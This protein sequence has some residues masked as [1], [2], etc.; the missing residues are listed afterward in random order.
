M[1]V[2]AFANFFVVLLLVGGGFGMGW[3][4][5][6]LESQDPAGSTESLYSGVRA[7]YPGA[8][9]DGR[10]AE[11]PQRA[12]L[13]DQASAATNSAPAAAPQQQAE[14]RAVDAFRELLDARAYSAAMDLYTR[15]ERTGTTGETAELK[16][17]VVSYLERYLRDRDDTALTGLVDAFLARYYDDVDVILILARHHLQSDYP[18]EAAGSFQLA[19]TYAFMPAEQQKVSR[20]FSSFVQEVDDL[21]A[22]QAHWKK[23]ITFYETLAVMDLSQPIH[24]LRQAELYLANGEAENGR[25][26]LNRLTG[27]ATV[28]D[29]ARA[30]LRAL[31]A[32]AEGVAARPARTAMESIALGVAG[33]HYHLPLR[34]NDATDVRLI[35]DTG[36]STTT[37]TRSKFDSINRYGQFIE[38]GPQVF[39]TA[40]GVARGTV[41]RAARVQI[42]RHVLT[43]VK[44][45]VL[46]FDM[47]QG[48][49]GLLG[50]NVL[51]NFRFQLDQDEQRL[52]LRPR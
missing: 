9:Y 52:Y 46:D 23:L 13:Q 32:G 30:M 50:M 5:R 6:G 28:A 48:I 36:A 45:A 7:A 29:D 16:S 51:S 37:L 47:P 18:A 26:L 38:L 8:D 21:L 25:Q 42:G 44:I 24:L 39:N 20:A 14:P 2:S 31:D 12:K 19:F 27:Q 15:V 34:L 3:W 22:A 43:D 11:P 35:I 49:D 40:S 17:L 4:M 41:Y 10:P 33:N 1:R